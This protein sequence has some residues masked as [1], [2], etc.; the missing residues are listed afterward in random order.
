MKQRGYPLPKGLKDKADRI[1]LVMHLL[2]FIILSL[3]GFSMLLY[4]SM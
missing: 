1:L 2:W 4:F 3:L